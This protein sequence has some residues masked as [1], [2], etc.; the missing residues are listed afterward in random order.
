M[1][2]RFDPV[3]ALLGRHAIH[4]FKSCQQEF[5]SLLILVLDLGLTGGLVQLWEHQL[6]FRDVLNF[7]LVFALLYRSLQ[8]WFVEIFM[9]LIIFRNL[10]FFFFIRIL[11]SFLTTFLFLLLGGMHVLFLFL[12]KFLG[13]NLRDRPVLFLI[14][15]T[16]FA[17]CGGNRGHALLPASTGRD[18]RF[19]WV[20]FIALSI[21]LFVLERLYDYWYSFRLFLHRLFIEILLNAC[22]WLLTLSLK[23]I[24]SGD[25]IVLWWLLSKLSR[26]SRTRLIFEWLC[27]C[28]RRCF[29]L[30]CT[31]AF[32]FQQA[33]LQRFRRQ[34]LLAL[35]SHEILLYVRKSYRISCSLLVVHLFNL[36]H[37]IL[38]SRSFGL[39]ISLLRSLMFRLLFWWCFAHRGL[40]R[41]EI[42]GWRSRS[43]KNILWLVALTMGRLLQVE[44][45][46]W[47]FQ[48]IDW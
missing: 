5:D 33:T 36:L 35:H 17:R 3:A 6:L 46:T 13:Q 41:L 16:I 22:T 30:F 10:A 38:L 32:F 9:L 8:S 4:V 40:V 24:M 26:V 48:D 29:T 31:L 45:R 28:S 14:L 18:I 20:D 39:W 42:I 47:C 1:D 37:L 34:N 7:W 23:I 12:L 25:L 11:T 19:S 44:R 27:H 15:F 43:L 21:F 2:E